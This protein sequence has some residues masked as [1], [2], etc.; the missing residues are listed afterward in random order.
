MTREHEDFLA[1]VR[2]TLGEAAGIEATLELALG[3][4]D[5]QSGTVHLLADD[6]A[7]HLEASARIPPP[8]LDK[9]RVIPVGR[10]MAG[11][12]VERGEPVRT[13][14]LQTDETGDVRPGAKET[15][16]Q[17]SICVPVLSGDRA[18]GALG[19]AN[20]EEREFTAEEAELL[21]EIGRA[22]AERF[23]R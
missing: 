11:L 6:G 4:L 15:G 8:V 10:G 18:V 21:V 16:L 9:I 22:I 3:R 23:A 5:A 7:L 12:A 2:R 1:D 20:T 17:G 14:N 13:C 19:V